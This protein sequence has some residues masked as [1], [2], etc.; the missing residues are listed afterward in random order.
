ML[1]LS[2]FMW[3]GALN[4]SGVLLPCSITLLA[5]P[6][7]CQHTDIYSQTYMFIRMQSPHMA[8][9]AKLGLR[10]SGGMRWR[11]WYNEWRLAARY[12]AVREI[13]LYHVGY[14]YIVLE[15]STGADEDGVE[16]WEQWEQMQMHETLLA[17][18]NQGDE[19]DQ[20]QD[21][22]HEE[23]FEDVREP[24]VGSKEEKDKDKA[25]E[26]EKEE[27]KGY[28]YYRGIGMMKESI[29]SAAEVMVQQ[30]I[31]GQGK[32]VS[33]LSLSL[34]AVRSLYALQVRSLEI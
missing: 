6:M 4:R 13:L 9:G 14:E 21:Q 33:P 26:K 5:S 23:G 30:K 20:D 18:H 2:C 22:D 24:A 29:L 31:R 7:T 1:S 32:G 34:R 27:D 16:K 19:S 15:R 11:S 12:V 28:I 10:C 25:K 17:D 8:V 3:I